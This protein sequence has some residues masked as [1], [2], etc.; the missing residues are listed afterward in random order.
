MDIGMLIFLI[1]LWNVCGTIILLAIAGCTAG[2]LEKCQGWECV[3]PY[4]VYNYCKSVN[5]FGATVLALL[6]TAA[7]PAMALIYWFYKLYTVGR[8]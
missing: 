2:W 6:C 1:I 5:W 8:K 4:W 7:S 3:N